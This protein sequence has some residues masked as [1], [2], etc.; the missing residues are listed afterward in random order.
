MGQITMNMK[1]EI[2]EFEFNLTGIFQSIS[3]IVNSTHI[4]VL[5][6]SFHCSTKIFYVLLQNALDILSF[7]QNLDEI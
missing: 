5:Q 1:S 6:K 4:L 7:Q 2:I 3:G